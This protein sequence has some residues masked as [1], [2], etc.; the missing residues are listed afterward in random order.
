MRNSFEVGWYIYIII[1]ER[2]IKDDT[3]LYNV[4]S[5]KGKTDTKS[6]NFNWMCFDTVNSACN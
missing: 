5:R 1:N 3:P 6:S 4:Y 2:L